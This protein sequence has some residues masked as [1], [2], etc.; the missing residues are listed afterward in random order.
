MPEKAISCVLLADRHHGLAEGI[1]GLLETAFESVFLVADGTSLLEG[2]DRLQPDVAVVDLSLAQGMNLTW[3]QA[4]KSRRA[5]LKV[6]VLS[7]HDEPNV[8]RATLEAGA[9]AFVLKRNISTELLAAVDTVRGRPEPVVG[10]GAS[11]DA[12]A[13]ANGKGAK[14]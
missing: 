12:H 8:R 5:G 11:A 13:N 6:I 3:L 14:R 7:V 1:R 4:M 10:P 2:A 9:D